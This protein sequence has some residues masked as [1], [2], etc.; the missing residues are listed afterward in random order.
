MREVSA[1]RNT[2]APARRPSP[3]PDP[4]QR[5][6]DEPGIKLPDITQQMQ[7]GPP[8]EFRAALP[9]RVAPAR[10]GE[11]PPAWFASVPALD[12]PSPGRRLQLSLDP[13]FRPQW[14]RALIVAALSTVEETR[15]LDMERVITSMARGQELEFVPF[16]RARTLRKG[17]YCWL[18]VGPGMEP[19]RRDQEEL[20]AVLER[21]AGRDRVAVEMLSD[22]ARLPTNV[23]FAHTPVLILSDLGANRIPGH[24]PAIIPRHWVRFANQARGQ[25]ASHVVAFVP[26]DVIRVSAELRRAI[27]VVKWDR[28]VSVQSVLRARRYVRE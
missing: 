10:T 3:R 5:P 14:L 28:P 7:T 18:D 27:A 21:V 17:V 8:P 20:V 25:G 1:L 19:F 26:G 13:L 23:Y 4:P 9:E 16:R 11:T 2:T 6:S 12:P 15:E 24:A 22:D